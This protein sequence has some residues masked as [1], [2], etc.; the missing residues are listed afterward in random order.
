MS[1]N[2]GELNCVCLLI[3]IILLLHIYC[4]GFILFYTLCHYYHPL[5]LLLEEEEGG[6]DE[7]PLYSIFLLVSMQ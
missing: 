7:G 6:G 5:L 2:C 4:H 1:P 3:K